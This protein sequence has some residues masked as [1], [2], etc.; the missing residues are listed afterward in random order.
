MRC[1]CS[2]GVLNFNDLWFAYPMMIVLKITLPIVFL[3]L[4]SNFGPR[5]LPQFVVQSAPELAMAIFILSNLL[6]WPPHGPDW[7]PIDVD[8]SKPGDRPE[9]IVTIVA[10]IVLAGIAFLLAFTPNNGFWRGP[11]SASG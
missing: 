2:S 9:V 3:V 5:H 6:L 4:V 10:H 11:M 7:K 1:F 8:W